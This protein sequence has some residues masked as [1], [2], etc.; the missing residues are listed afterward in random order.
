M[1]EYIQ[2]VGLIIHEPNTACLTLTQKSIIC[3]YRLVPLQYC[4]T[5]CGKRGQMGRTT[6]MGVR[7][8]YLRV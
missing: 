2:T 1:E 5:N 4:L 8:V 6:V 3:K 7:I